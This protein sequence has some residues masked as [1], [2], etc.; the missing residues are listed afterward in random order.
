MTKQRRV[1]VHIAT[2]ADG[3]IAR[4]MIASRMVW[5]NCITAFISNLDDAASYGTLLFVSVFVGRPSL[6]A[7][8][9]RSGG[10]LLG[11]VSVAGAVLSSC[12]IEPRS[13]A[14]LP[15]P[16]CAIVVYNRTQYALEIRMRVRRLT[17]MPIGALN[18]GELLNYSLP[19][20]RAGVWVSGIPIPSQVGA[21]ASFRLVE[22]R[23]ELVEGERVE[24]A[25][26]WP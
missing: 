18:P 26:H 2:S 6:G 5:F 8:R 22:G 21:R 23:A 25:L 13:E 4:P 9:I 1:I 12:A 3:Y 15:Q 19:C 11:L 16:S 14:V 10:A 7:L 24:I 17:T 20:A